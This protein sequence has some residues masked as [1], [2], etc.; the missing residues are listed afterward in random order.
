MNKKITMLSNR[1]LL[2]HLAHSHTLTTPTCERLHDLPPQLRNTPI[3]EV[4]QI[5]L[6]L[7]RRYYQEPLKHQD[8]LH[9]TLDTER[10]LISKL[11]DYDHEVFACLYLDIKNRLI[12]FEVLFHGGLNGSEVHPRNLVKQALHYNAAGIIL[13]HNHPSGCTDPSSA[14]Y[15]ITQQLN[16]LLEQLDINLLDHMIVA[17]NQVKSCFL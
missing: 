3:S 7:A 9:N 1:E 16:Q 11:R 5:S 6:E 15:K 2:Q 10:F 14:D 12:E 4:L 8:I 13:A 17:G